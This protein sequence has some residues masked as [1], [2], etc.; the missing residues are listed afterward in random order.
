MKTKLVVRLPCYEFSASCPEQIDQLVNY[1][2]RV[3]LKNLLLRI[4]PVFYTDFL[5][6]EENEN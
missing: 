5:E 1:E 4:S 2:M 6:V 3:Y